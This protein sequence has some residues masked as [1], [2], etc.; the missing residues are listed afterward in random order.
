MRIQL[1][2]SFYD[3]YLAAFYAARPGLG[4]RPY[5]EQLE[6]LLDAF[7]QQYLEDLVRRSDGN[8]A[9]AARIGGV[10]RKTLYRLLGRHGLK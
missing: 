6:A 5:A 2:W 7:E 8:L 1:L 3:H 10:D 4:Q 9:K